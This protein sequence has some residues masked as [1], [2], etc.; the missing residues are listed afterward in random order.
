MINILGNAVKFTP[1]DGTIT[2]RAHELSVED[3]KVLYRFQFE[4]TGIGMSEEFQKK[5][6]EA[7][8]QESNGSRTTYQG[9]GLGMAITKQFVDLMGGTI[10]VQ[11]QQGK[12]SCFTVELTF[13]IDIDKQL[14]VKAAT[15][16]EEEGEIDLSGMRVMLVE[17]NE[18][19]M[20]IAQ[21]ILEGE[22]VETVPAENGK[23]ALDTFNS[24][25]VGTFDIILMD[26]MMPVMNGLEA[27]RAI[28]ASEHPEAKTIPIVAMSA[29]AYAE[30][31][32][33]A[34]NA[35]MN[36]HIAKPIDFDRLF[37]VLNHY[38][39]DKATE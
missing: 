11:S 22:G 25:P 36:G 29:N 8:S 23:I 28:R 3:N 24:S 14:E 6:F 38:K 27:T 31:V 39:K 18:L 21:E 10:E 5:I 16:E 12:G 35:G 33:A 32:N 2:F 4:D 17:D 15:E 13:D 26:L 19:N 37:S 30:D 7:F 20:E 34:L 1:E 9:T